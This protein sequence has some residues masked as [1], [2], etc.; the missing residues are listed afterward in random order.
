MSQVV[1]E[2]HSNILAA[3]LAAQKTGAASKTSSCPSTPKSVNK[4]SSLYSS[5]EASSTAGDS[6]IAALSPPEK[7]AN[8]TNATPKPKAFTFSNSS[9]DKRPIRTINAIRTQPS[10][11][12]SSLANAAK[13]NAMGAVPEKAT[14]RT[15]LQLNRKPIAACRSTWSGET[16]KEKEASPTQIA[17]ARRI[18]SI[19]DTPIASRSSL[20]YCRD[21]ISGVKFLI[22]SGS[23]VSVIPRSMAGDLEEEPLRFTLKGAGGHGINTHGTKKMKISMNENNSFIW[24]FI[25]ADVSS[26]IIGLDFLTAFRLAI[27][28]FGNNVVNC[29]NHTSIPCLR[30]SGTSQCLKV[31]IHDPAVELLAKFPGLTEPNAFRTIKHNVKHEIVINGDLSKVKAEQRNFNVKIAEQI[32]KHFERLAAL[33]HVRLSKSP[34]SSPVTVVKKASGELRVCGD[35]RRLNMATQADSFSL[36][37][38]HA[39]NRDLRDCKIFTCIDLKNAYHQIPMREEDIWLT[40]VVTPAGNYEYTVCPF[41]LK[42]ASQTF[43][44]FLNGLLAGLPN[45]WAFLDDIMIGSRSEQEHRRHVEA[46]LKRLESAGLKINVEKSQF[47]RPSIEFLGYTLSENGIRPKEAKVQAVNDYPMPDTVG[48]LKRFLGMIN[49]YNRFIPEIGW[50]QKPL[51]VYLS[52]P[53]KENNVKIILTTEQQEAVQK[54]KDSLAGATTLAHPQPDAIL[55]LYVDASKGGVGGALHQ[56]YDGKEEPLYFVSRA[57]TKAESNWAPYNLELE[58][59]FFTVNKLTDQLIG[60]EVILYSDHKPLIHAL[61]NPKPKTPLEFRRLDTITRLVDHF[62]HISGENNTVADALSRVNCNA[63][64]LMPSVDYEQIFEAQQEDSELLQ[65]VQA[66]EEQF[67]LIEKRMANGRFRIWHQID[68]AYNQLVY[69]PQS[70]RK[71]LI[72]EFH[73]QCHAGYKSTTRHLARLFYWPK[74]KQDV[75]DTVRICEACQKAKVIRANQTPPTKIEM[76]KSRF[77]TLHVD[78]VGPLPPSDGYTH[79]LTVVDRFSRYM[80]AMPLRSIKTNAVLYALMIGWIQHFGLPL[81]IVTDRG[82]QF[83]SHTMKNCANFFG[84]YHHTTTAFHPQSN[85]MIERCHRM[86]KDSLRCIET[87]DWPKRTPMIVLAWNNSVREETGHSPSQIVFGSTMRLPCHFFE[88]VEQQEPTDEML[89]AFMAEM[90]ELRARSADPHVANRSRFLTTEAMESCRF[91]YVKNETKQGL[92]DNYTGPFKVLSRNDY[93]MV[94]RRPDG[95]EDAVNRARC[96]PAYLLREEC[97][98]A[99]NEQRTDQSSSVF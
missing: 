61:R 18:F 21:L 31:E 89:E 86:L 75:R 25:V 14:F 37:H 72:E 70:K 16:I 55:K 13:R 78:L 71:E 50:I 54:L 63:I 36:P 74:M 41:G 49:F 30:G 43:Q 38:I 5:P 1:A 46:V 35:Y 10:A 2:S 94:I 11:A 53:K 40:N 7:A 98:T 9:T 76:P 97:D 84:V 88:D 4:T 73:R 28:P 44:R 48:K 80:V 59:A 24:T 60:R 51:G 17:T 82:S 45:V 52:K 62:E 57:F 77:S 22:D 64:R 29:L 93:N 39:C 99:V 69:V 87:R 67:K 47:F 19:D 79:L 32:K 27:M 58:A 33:G 90:T 68:A 8:Q 42:T 12:A 95:R 83:T 56:Y 23:E 85:S 34:V 6:R 92:Q 20:M 91:V 65:H 81:E 66:D 3:A 26:P 15:L 96:K